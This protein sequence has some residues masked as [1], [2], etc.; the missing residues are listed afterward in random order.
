MANATAKN[1]EGHLQTGI[2]LLIVALICWAGVE[3]VNVGR[4]V[5]VLQERQ[6][7]QGRLITE[8][9]QDLRNWSELYYRKDTA[10]RQIGEIKS[11]MDELESRVTD[12]ENPQ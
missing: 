3:L 11:S 6:L 4:T 9:R 12:L 7:H 1:F 10:N 2:Q 8:L 5:A